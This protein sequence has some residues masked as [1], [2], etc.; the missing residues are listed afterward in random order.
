MCSL[1][2]IYNHF[3]FRTPSTSADDSTG[4][5]FDGVSWFRSSLCRDIGTRAAFEWNAWRTPCIPRSWSRRSACQRLCHCTPNTVPHST[6]CS[7]RQMMC[8]SFASPP[9][10]SDTYSKDHHFRR[11]YI[12]GPFWSN[13]PFYR[14]QSDRQQFRYTSA[15]IAPHYTN[16]FNIQSDILSEKCHSRK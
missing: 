3:S 16:V 4:T 2:L 15:L 10:W 8:Y 1:I 12:F 14:F 13:F 11:Q 6:C 9:F 5:D 7:L